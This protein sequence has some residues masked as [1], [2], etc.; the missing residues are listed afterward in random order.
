MPLFSG[1]QQNKLKKNSMCYNSIMITVKNF[2]NYL[3]KK[4]A[5][6]NCHYAVLTTQVSI[7]AILVV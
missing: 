6:V 3:I 5:I 2:F 7:R 1:I 4:E